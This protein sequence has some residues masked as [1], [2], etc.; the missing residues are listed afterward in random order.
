MKELKVLDVFENTEDKKIESFSKSLNSSLEVQ[1]DYDEYV[2]GDEWIKVF[3]DSLMYIENILKN[4]NRFIINEEEVVKIELAR[5]ITVDSIKHLSKNTNFIQD[6]DE[7]NGDVKPSKILNIN[8]EESF[9]TYENRFIYT[10]IKNMEMFIHRQKQFMNLEAANKNKRKMDYSASSKFAGEDI[11]IS[12]SMESKQDNSKKQETEMEVLAA[13]IK[14]IEDYI[15]QFKSADLFQTLK[16]LN[17]AQVTSPIKR[18]NVILKNVNFQNAVSLWNYIQ[19]NIS[20]MSTTNKGSDT[21]KDDKGLKEMIDETFMLNYL[22]VDSLNNKEEPTKE[23]KQVVT[24]KIVTNLVQKIVATNQEITQEELT[25]L[26]EKEFVIINNK[27]LADSDSI[28][29]VFKTAI[30]KYNEETDK[31]TFDSEEDE[32][33]EDGEEK[34]EKSD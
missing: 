14:K 30:K 2:Y 19:N 17:V 13:R 27:D 10:L 33:L 24:Q 1:H 12:V 31:A 23:K 20:D 22:V 9:N 6:I 25:E 21:L 28:K 4:P 15:I 16:R 29:K 18:T 32:G 34:D 11:N 8:K 5:R 7:E 26:V 3:E